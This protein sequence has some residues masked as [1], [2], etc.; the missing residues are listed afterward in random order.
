MLQAHR[1]LANLMWA[2]V[3]GHAG[4]AVLHQVCGHRVLQRI[5]GGRTG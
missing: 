4:M 1:I 3:V 2:Y 5:F